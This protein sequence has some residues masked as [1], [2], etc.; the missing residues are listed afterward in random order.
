MN[1]ALGGGRGGATLYLDKN[2]YTF[3]YAPSSSAVLRAVYS[4]FVSVHVSDT[5]FF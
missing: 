5:L 1:D 3:A 4:F 2:R